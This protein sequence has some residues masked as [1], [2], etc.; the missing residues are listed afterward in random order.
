MSKS[1]KIFVGILILLFIG[2][3]VAG[4]Y[5]PK[6]I[7]WSPTYF[8]KDKIP[9]GLYVLDQEHEQ[10]FAPQKV[11]KFGK[12]P[13]EYFDSKFSLND[14]TYSVKGTFL[15]IDN[16]FDIDEESVKELLYF[17]SH[18]NSIFISTGNF[19]TQLA[20]S[21]HF[22]TEYDQNISD[23]IQLNV[24]NQ[25]KKN[26]FYYQKGIND[27]YFSEID[28]SKTSVLGYQTR[29]NG[30][31]QTN[32]IRVPYGDGFFYLH[33][34][35][36]AF[37]NYY[38]LKKETNYAADVLSYISAENEVFWKVQRY[39]GKNLSESPLRFIKSQ[40]ALKWAWY[41]ALFGMLFFIIF[42]T[43]RRQRVIPIEVPLKNTT[44]DFTKT[45]GN[46]YYQE[47]D[48]L[49]IIDKKIIFFLEKVRNEYY[50]DTFNLDE[51]FV[52]KLHQKSGKSKEQIQEL[53]NLINNL[54]NKT[55]ATET[56]VVNLNNQIEK[57]YS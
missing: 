22:T 47:K 53:F 11:I 29:S 46:L 31:N 6:P 30:K 26:N 8:L 50:L 44:L 3:I 4:A 25:K 54:R 28:T 5:S 36:V 32:F 9:F 39:E 7:D 23:S 35:P 45:I 37:T 52:K 10:F 51:T 17:A 38:L 14:T 40:P 24:V 34:Q 21:L 49:N 41:F 48:Y 43:K 27:T 2:I 55:T 57:F 15:Y 19:P 12:T 1:I 20:D 13:Y 56:D 42:N 16:Q 18:G 33:S